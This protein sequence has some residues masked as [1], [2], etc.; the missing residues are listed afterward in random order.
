MKFE[1]STF[2]ESGELVL[3]LNDEIVLR[4]TGKVSLK[5]DIGQQY[6]VSWTVMGES[7]TSYSI[8]ISSP[9]LAEFHLVKML[10]EDQDRLEFK[11]YV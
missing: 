4:N 5:I 2:I 11:F 3:K 8:T 7:G 9:P 6:K 10:G 1:A